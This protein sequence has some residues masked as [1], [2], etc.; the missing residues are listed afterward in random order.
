MPSI[1]TSCALR[2]VL[3]LAYAK[4]KRTGSIKLPARTACSSDPTIALK[5]RI[6]KDR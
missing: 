1:S 6:D 4:Q 5:K 2:N 3:E